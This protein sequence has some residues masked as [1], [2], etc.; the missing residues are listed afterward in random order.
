MEILI[1]LHQLSWLSC[2]CMS[3][4]WASLFSGCAAHTSTLN[5]K[6]VHAPMQTP[7]FSLCKFTFHIKGWLNLLV[8]IWV[9]VSTKSSQFCLSAENTARFA[10]LS[11]KTASA[12][13]IYSLIAQMCVLK[14]F[15]WLSLGVLHVC[16]RIK[17]KTLTCKLYS[18]WV[19]LCTLLITY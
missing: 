15:F 6:C 17:Q 3:S 1:W 11:L 2:S 13:V 5:I 7:F 14:P 8:C 12:A 18:N 16:K 9:F 10:P 4:L 19:R